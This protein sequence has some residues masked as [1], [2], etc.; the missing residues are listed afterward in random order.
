MS[1]Y[2]LIC[3]LILLLTSSGRALTWKQA[4]ELAERNNY[5]LKSAASQTEAARWNYLK[6]FSPFLPQL[7]ASL[8]MGESSSGAF[9]EPVKSDAYG[10]TATQTLFSGLDNYYSYLSARTNYDSSLAGLRKAR[11]DVGFLVRQQF[12]EL[13][14]ANENVKLL[15]D[16]LERRWDNTALIELQFKNGREDKGTLLK[17]KADEAE[18]EYNLRSA[19]RTRQLSKLKLTQLISFE[20]DKAEGELQVKLPTQ[21]DFDKLL[22]SVPG[23]VIALKAAESAELAYQQTVS[24]FLPSVSL[25]GSIRK[26]GTDWS[27]L[28]RSNSWSLSVSYPF[29]PGG[30]NVADR[31]RFAALND[32]AKQDLI[33]AKNDLRYGLESAYEQLKDSLEAQKVAQLSEAAAKLRAE[34]AGTKY[35]NGLIGYDEWVI[36]ENN[37]INSQKS[38]LAR[39]RSALL[40]EAAWVNSYGGIVK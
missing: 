29:F 36:I 31:Y 8:S 26:S 1:K 30:S 24:E 10:L 25:S 14:V 34:I 39:K 38:S 35:L 17:T 7:S 16:I 27:A 3:L 23:Y 20:V 28:N 12:I 19:G 6:S 37:Y 2:F 22:A 13:A 33:K 18:A 5:E 40:A 21:P 32:Q 11:S 9:T 15:I 4:L